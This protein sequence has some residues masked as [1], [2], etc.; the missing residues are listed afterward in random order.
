MMW[1]ERERKK[2]AIRKQQEGMTG[3]Q[4][5]IERRKRRDDDADRVKAATMEREKEKESE[6]ERES[7]VET[8]KSASGTLL[9]F[10]SRAIDRSRGGGTGMARAAGVG[11]GWTS[12]YFI[13]H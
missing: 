9:V 8:V 4:S 12:R 2:S 1:K 13:C 5:V 11:G 6:R 10:T 3:E 7:I